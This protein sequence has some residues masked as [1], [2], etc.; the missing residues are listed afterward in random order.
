[1]IAPTVQRKI[2]PVTVSVPSSLS[3]VPTAVIRLHPYQE[4]PENTTA[5]SSGVS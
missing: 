2:G 1:M 3:A 5:S 4:P